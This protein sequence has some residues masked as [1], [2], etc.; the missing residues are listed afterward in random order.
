M[1]FEQKAFIASGRLSD[2]DAGACL[3]LSD[4]DSND[5]CS[6]RLISLQSRLTTVWTVW[7]IWKKGSW[8]YPDGPQRTD[9]LPP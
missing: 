9:N 1:A 7:K 3:T 4:A 8:K 6:H 5:S 2:G